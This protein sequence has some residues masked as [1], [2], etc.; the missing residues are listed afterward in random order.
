MVMPKEL[1]A[2]LSAVSVVRVRLEDGAT[3]GCSLSHDTKVRG[4]RRSTHDVIALPQQASGLCSRAVLAMPER[5]S[6]INLREI[7]GVTTP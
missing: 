4:N 2:V 7:G 5:I 6:G 3:A 1:A